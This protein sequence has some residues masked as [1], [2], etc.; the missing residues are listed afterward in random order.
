[1]LESFGKFGLKTCRFCSTIKAMKA[2]SKISKSF[3]ALVLLGLILLLPRIAYSAQIKESLDQLRFTELQ[4][5]AVTTDMYLYLGWGMDEKKAMKEA[6]LRAISDL[7]LLRTQ[8]MGR[9][10]SDEAVP[11]KDLTLQMI[12]HLT[13]I[14]R[15]IE[16]KKDPQIKEEFTPFNGLYEKYAE[17]FKSLWQKSAGAAEPERKLNSFEEELR[18][19]EDEQVKE[20]YPQAVTNIEA[21]NYAAAYEILKGMA[22]TIQ[23]GPATDIIKLRLSDALLMMDYNAVP[24]EGLDAAQKGLDLL[25]EIIESGRYSPVLYEVFYKWRTTEQQFNHGMSNMSAIPNKDYN[26]K[27]RQ[28]IQTIKKYLADNPADAWARTQLDLLWDLP[29]I[30]RGGPYGND[31][32]IH[33]GMLYTGLKNQ[34]EGDESR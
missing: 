6:S 12:A 20:R 13:A 16:N 1:M 23:D 27:R 10:F 11:L 18:W 21:K 24:I 31:N 2:K 30:Q 7:D 33:W 34:D 9:D 22:E 29:N 26:E 17:G 15:G 4:L 8:V 3:N 14:Y 19:I 25:A 5:S 28:V 32:L